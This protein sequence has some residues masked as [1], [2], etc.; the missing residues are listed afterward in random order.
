MGIHLLVL[1]NLFVEDYVNLKRVNTGL[2]DNV[3]RVPNLS[4]IK[5]GRIKELT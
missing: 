3:P 1:I 2:R 4:I 5:D